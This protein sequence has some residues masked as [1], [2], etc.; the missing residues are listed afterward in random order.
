MSGERCYG[1]VVISTPTCKSCITKD[2]IFGC[3]SSQCTSNTMIWQNAKELNSLYPLAFESYGAWG[4]KRSHSLR[5]CEW[6]FGRAAYD[7]IAGRNY[8]ALQT[9]D[10]SKWLTGPKCAVDGASAE[11]S[12]SGAASIVTL[13]FCNSL[14]SQQHNSLLTNIILRGI[15]FDLL[16]VS[17]GAANSQ[18]RAIF[19]LY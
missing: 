7:S 1:D 15:K 13:S 17:C 8:G 6:Y 5:H 12:R 19:V 11:D 16:L 9:V 4:G 2:R 18:R 3:N 10:C 14:A